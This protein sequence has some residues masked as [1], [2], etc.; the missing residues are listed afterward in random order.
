MQSHIY[1]FDNKS[2][3]SYTNAKILY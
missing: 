1:I 3:K 2:R